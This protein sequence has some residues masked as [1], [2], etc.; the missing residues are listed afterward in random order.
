VVIQEKEIQLEDELNHAVE[1]YQS[2]AKDLAI[3]KRHRYE[4]LQTHSEKIKKR[5]SE[6]EHAQIDLAVQ[7]MTRLSKELGRFNDEDSRLQLYI[8]NT[9]EQLK[10][11]R[12]R[13]GDARYAHQ[14]R[15]VND[16]M[17]EVGMNTK[18]D[19][20][21]DDPISEVTN[22]F[23]N[24]KR[25]NESNTNR[26]KE[27]VKT[28]NGNET[29]TVNL[30]TDPVMI[31]EY[32]LKGIKLTDEEKDIVTTSLGPRKMEAKSARVKKAKKPKPEEKKSLLPPEQEISITVARPLTDAT[33]HFN[34]DRD[35]RKENI[36]FSVDEEDDE[37]TEN[38]NP[39]VDITQAENLELALNIETSVNPSDE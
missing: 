7:E 15:G 30:M 29:N 4:A 24:V 11:I 14:M 5:K 13:V 3:E 38:V 12:R 17:R 6:N 8:A 32:Y 31:T 18:I 35:D 22:T 21:E 39:E 10:E 28:I 16:L 25:Q 36:E 27:S 33:Q 1:T 26:L 37:F 9:A 34:V 20:V 23:R 19:A 2:R